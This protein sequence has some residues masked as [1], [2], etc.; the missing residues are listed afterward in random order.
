MSG[1]EY[2]ST[3]RKNLRDPLKGNEDWKNTPETI[4]NGHV[5]II[6]DGHQA[7]KEKHLFSKQCTQIFLDELR[8][9]VSESLSRVEW[10]GVMN[11]V[12]DAVSKRLFSEFTS[13][14][15]SKVGCT[16]TVGVV[17]Q[18]THEV[19]TANLG[20]SRAVIVRHGSAKTKQMTVDHKP[21]DPTEMKRLKK[22]GYR[23][24]LS[25]SSDEKSMIRNRL[26]RKEFPN[27]D[28]PVM[29]TNRVVETGLNVSRGFGDIPLGVTQVTQLP[30]SVRP[31]IRDDQL[32]MGDAL[33][34]AS[35][36][37]W[38]VLENNEL[39]SDAPLQQIASDMIGLSRRRGSADDITLFIIRKV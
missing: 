30:N 36:G 38:D 13:K 26:V 19:V 23:V 27:D 5:F 34:I 39:N 22:L 6:A 25:N 24:S 18:N 7:T 1:I 21:Y 35:D 32:K 11:Q 33:V 28:I 17:L 20:D 14:Q 8:S 10:K 2:I 37:V 3:T 9:K 29:D 12:F 4:G 31:C 16:F 15:L